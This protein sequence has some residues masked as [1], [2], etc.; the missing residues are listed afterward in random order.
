MRLGCWR[1]TLTVMRLLAGWSRWSCSGGNDELRNEVVRKSR[2]GGSNLAAAP[3]EEQSAPRGRTHDRDSLAHHP[4]ACR[5]LHSSS[6][7]CRTVQWGLPHHRVGATAP[8][9]GGI[10]TVLGRWL[11]RDAHGE[12]VRR[13]R[14]LQADDGQPLTQVQVGRTPTEDGAAAPTE[15]YETPH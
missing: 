3:K 2:L 13:T 11:G 10:R 4:A 12:A 9:N 1:F 15:Q 8:F 5:A 14:H 6:G 7:G